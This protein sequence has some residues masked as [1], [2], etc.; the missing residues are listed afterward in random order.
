M[1]LGKSRV[2]QVQQTSPRIFMAL[3]LANWPERQRH[4]ESATECTEFEFSVGTDEG[5]PDLTANVSIFM[6]IFA[7]ATSPASSTVDSRLT[8][9]VDRRV[10]YNEI[11]NMAEGRWRSLEKMNDSLNDC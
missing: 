1:S 8:T 7:S 9:D 3:H 6:A 10:V 11:F 2:F 5:Q 4:K